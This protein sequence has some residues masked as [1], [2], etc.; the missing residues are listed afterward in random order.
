MQR[1]N[2]PDGDWHAGDPSQGVK[3]TV[4]T[5]PYM[6]SLQEEV[7]GVVEGC[8]MQLDPDD[9]GQL[10]KAIRS[11]GQT[12]GDDRYAQLHGDPKNRF[13]VAD[14]VDDDDAVTLRQIKAGADNR[15]GEIV[16]EMRVQPRA[17]WLK[18]NGVMLN[19]ADYPDLWAYAQASGAIVAEK[20]W[21][22][23]WWGA[24]SSGDG[25]TTFR[26][27]DLRGTFLRVWDDTR[28][29]DAGRN[30]GAFQGTANV[31]HA[32][33]ASAAAVG[34]HVHGAWTDAQGVH[35][36]GGGTGGVG[37]HGHG[38]NDPGHAH[39]TTVPYGG[40]G[41]DAISVVGPNTAHGYFNTN[42]AGTGISIAAGGA[43][44]HEIGADGNHGHNVGIG[45][46][47]NH[48]HTITIAADGANEARPVNMAV[49]AFIRAY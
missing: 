35:A 3:G 12:D 40:G 14:A 7:C 2:T 8:G 38:V 28:G 13:S 33:G 26:I 4:V 45:G 19:R 29:L 43:H 37:D 30:I 9:N 49:S 17:G 34:D 16:F 41:G 44:A 39:S 20:D 11:I 27:P 5:Q 15:I 23:N 42:A 32:H 48:S 18:L 25:A 24:F 6:Q 46:A 21:P 22:N 1:I 31:S 10:L 47:G 36:H